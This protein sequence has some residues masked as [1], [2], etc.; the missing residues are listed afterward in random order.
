[1]RA[2]EHESPVK[3]DPRRMSGVQLA[4]M[5]I[6]L[7]NKYDLLMQCM[8]CG[9]TWSPTTGAHGRLPEGYWRCPNRCNV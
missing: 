6:R 8:N 4:R 1:M 5:G 2:V 7:L 3:A 9:E